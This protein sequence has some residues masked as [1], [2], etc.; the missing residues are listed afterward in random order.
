MPDIQLR[1]QKDL[2]VLSAPLDAAFARQGTDLA[3]DRQYLNLME[4]DSIADALNLEMA[5]GAQCLVTTT[6]D[7]TQARLAHVRMDA[8]ASRLAKAALDIAN[9]AQPQHV[10]VEIGPCGLPLDTSSKSSLN[11]N[12][13]QYADAARAFSGGTFDA[14]FLNGF[15]RIPDLK[16]A[17]MGVAQVTDKPVFVSVTL[18][19]E[20]QLDAAGQH[21][22]EAV[23]PD[24]AARQASDSPQSDEGARRESDGPGLDVVAQSTKMEAP[25]D[26]SDDLL[27]GFPFKGYSLY[28]DSTYS[29]KP[30][31]KRQRLS[32]QLWPEALDAMIDLG[33]SVVGFETA[34][35]INRAVE[36][37]RAAAERTD[38][39]ILV[40]LHVAQQPSKAATSGLVPLAD[41]DEYTPD[42]MALAA[43]KLYG[44]G[45]QFL[46]ATGL[47][48]PAYTGALAATVMGLDVH[49][50]AGESAG[51][52]L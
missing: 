4:P 14:F 32:P 45:V 17:L 41:I 36:Y 46:R 49:R 28:E 23:R 11:E 35:P 2:L 16:C 50:A 39:P 15:T 5:A 52:R 8:D 40:Q 22:D 18:G 42:T 26:D 25:Q 24:E 30:A 47:A 27:P 20:P 51:H 19:E 7:I 6:E 44:A 34:E 13:A 12:R 9:G 31:A 10:L 29:P 43:V 37:A 48:T 3:L 38:L 33:A 21:A 1:F